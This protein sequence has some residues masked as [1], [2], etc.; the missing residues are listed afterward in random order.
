M[1]RAVARGVARLIGAPLPEYPD[2]SPMPPQEWDGVVEDWNEQKAR[3][4]DE[5]LRTYRWEEEEREDR[6]W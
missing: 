5:L 4:D 6:E 1:L 3:L 2:G